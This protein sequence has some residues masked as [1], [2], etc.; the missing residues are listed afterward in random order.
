M[1]FIF[2]A[3]FLSIRFV[4]GVVHLTFLE[5]VIVTLPGKVSWSLAVDH[6]R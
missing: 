3:R 5:H 6:K 1:Y 4:V 2:S